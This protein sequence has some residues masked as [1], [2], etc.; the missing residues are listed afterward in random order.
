MMVKKDYQFKNFDEKITA[1]AMMKNVPISIK[2]ST[3][4][5]RE[6]KGKPVKKVL[7]YLERIIKKKDFLPLRKYRKKVPHRK[8]EAKSY[9]KSGRYPM[10]VCKAFIKLIESA[11]ANAVYKGLDEDKLLVLHAF[12]SKGYA[13]IKTQPKGHIGGK[14]REHK[15]THIEAVL[16]E[17]KGL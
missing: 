3:E 12:A 11:K 14:L 1:K 16:L 10:K 2:Y 8:G 4:L 7:A 13:R 6:I 15:S 5:C 17:S 9:T